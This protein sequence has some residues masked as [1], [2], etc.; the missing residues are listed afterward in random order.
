MRKNQILEYLKNPRISFL[1][2]RAD[3]V[4]RQYCTD[5]VFLR[6]IIEF[7]NFCLRNCLYCGLMKDNKK[8]RRYRMQPHEIVTI[9]FKIVEKGLKTV[10]LQSGDDFYYTRKIICNIIYKIK[11]KHPDVAITLSIGERP[12]DDYKAFKDEGVDRYLLKT[13][14]MNPKLYKRLHPGQD[15]KTRLKILDY[16]RKLDYQIGAGSIVG[17]PGQT[18]EDIADDILFLQ[19]LQ[20][21]MAGIGPFVPQKDT[22]LRD[23]LHGDLK[24]TLK[25][26]AL[27]RIVTKNSHFPATTAL[28]T[29]EATKGQ[30]KG[31]KAGCNVI[32][33]DFTP[34]FYRKNYKIYDEK[35]KIS[36]KKAKETILKAKRNISF[37]RGD[38]LKISSGR[39]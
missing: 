3:R 14:T 36:L 1:L 26:L 34:G 23:F 33:P 19:K 35:V 31:L 38:S 12:L 11:R 9:S 17:L 16:L 29:I 25:V 39:R 32:M 20:P 2:K 27:A 5:K 4:R 6:G 7:S 15:L 24:L 30:I 21:D 22:S 8:L 18:L 13:E 37:E 10:I 28:A